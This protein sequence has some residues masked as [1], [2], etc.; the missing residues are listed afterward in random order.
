MKCR[1]RQ[2]INTQTS[3]YII[4]QIMIKALE[5]NRAKEKVREV[6]DEGKDVTNF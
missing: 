2:S 1:G 3:K 5:N 4:Y 6:W